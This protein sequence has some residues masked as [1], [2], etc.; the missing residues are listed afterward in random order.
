LLWKQ[1][2]FP[3]CNI[4]NEKFLEFPGDFR[5]RKS[6][7]RLRPVLSQFRLPLATQKQHAKKKNTAKFFDLS[8]V[9]KPMVEKVNREKEALQLSLF[10]FAVKIF[11]LP[12]FK[13]LDNVP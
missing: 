6:P 11:S 10:D 13:N 7:G 2:F 9:K 12:K 3:V 5:L 1:Q 8:I 4:S